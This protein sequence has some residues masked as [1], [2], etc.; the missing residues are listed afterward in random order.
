MENMKLGSFQHKASRP[1]HIGIKSENYRKIATMTRSDTHEDGR[2]AAE[3]VRRFNAFPALMEALEAFVR[4][5][6]EYGFIN[7]QD[8]DPEGAES[9]A[10]GMAILALE[11]LKA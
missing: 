4:E 9:P 8:N 11:S 2:L 3:L 10:Y 5:V 6:D 7:S 1:V